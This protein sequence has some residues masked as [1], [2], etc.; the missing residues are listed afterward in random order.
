M[1]GIMNNTARQFNLKCISGG[2]RAVVRLAPG[3]NVV[4]DEHWQAF[5]PKSGKGVDPYVLG[6]KKA[7][8]IDYGKAMDDLELEREPDTI[9]KSKFEPLVKAKADLKESENGK[10]KAEAEAKEANAKAET[11][12]ADAKKAK[13]E[14]EK[15]Q[16]ELAALKKE[17]GKTEETDKTETKVDPKKETN[18][19]T[20]SK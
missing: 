6:L 18:K 15:A 19:D 13:V 11:A 9:S 3:F 17:Q 8:S 14:L 1:A 7:G 2:S 10:A 20:K 5:V 12:E 16:L 4:K